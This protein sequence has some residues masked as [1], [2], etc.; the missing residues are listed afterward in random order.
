M[1]FVTINVIV[2][3]LLLLA[4]IRAE[5]P[6]MNLRRKNLKFGKQEA[7]TVGEEEDFF[8]ELFAKKEGDGGQVPQMPSIDGGGNERSKILLWKL[9]SVPLS[10]GKQIDEMIYYYK[11]KDLMSVIG[12]SF[13]D[14]YSTLKKR[15]KKKA[16][17]TH[18]DKSRHPYAGYAFSILKLSYDTLSKEHSRD[19]YFEKRRKRRIR[20]MKRIVRQLKAALYNTRSEVERMMHYGLDTGEMGDWSND[21]L[22]KMM[23]KIRIG[24]TRVSYLSRADRYRMLLMNVNALMIVMGIMGAGMSLA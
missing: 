5:L 12:G 11:K 20:S 16:L 10:S 1:R 15:M 4:C 8:S 14:D 6:E 17:A 21:I 19:K 22:D 18:P 3:V 24:L 13:R 7:Q 23:D 2:L 9:F